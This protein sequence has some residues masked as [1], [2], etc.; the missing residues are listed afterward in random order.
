MADFCFELRFQVH[1]RVTVN[2][3]ISP[4][5]ARAPTT[6]LLKKWDKYQLAGI[7]TDQIKYDGILQTQIISTS[8]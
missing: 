3:I 2:M 8:D 4:T 5:Q 1:E 6:I 7:S